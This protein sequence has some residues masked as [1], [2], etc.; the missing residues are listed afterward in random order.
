VLRKKVKCNEIILFISAVAIFSANEMSYCMII[1][2]KI[3]Q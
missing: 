1:K 2:I 3:R